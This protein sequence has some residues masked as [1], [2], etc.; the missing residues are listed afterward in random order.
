M[1]YI[2]SISSFIVTLVSSLFEFKK[3]ETKDIAAIALS[4]AS[5]FISLYLMLAKRRDNEEE[6]RVTFL[7]SLSELLE[8]RKQI[9]D[10]ERLARQESTNAKLPPSLRHLRDKRE[11]LISRLVYIAGRFKLRVSSP[12]FIALAAALIDGGRIGEAILIYQ[13]AMDAA[14]NDW[15]TANAQRVYGRA[16]IAIGDFPEGRKHMLKAAELFKSLEN[17][18]AFERDRTLMQVAETYRR[19]IHISLQK[20]WTIFVSADFKSIDAILEEVRNRDMKDHFNAD[21]LPLKK[22]CVKNGIIKFSRRR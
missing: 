6:Y 2:D 13:Q 3:I 16:L 10:E 21:Y 8:T 15:E 19:L 4:A 5:L 20:S 7:E 11:M 1:S 17:N 9:E 18:S 22:D 12:E 14:R